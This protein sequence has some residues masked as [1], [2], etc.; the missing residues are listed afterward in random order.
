MDELNFAVK[1]ANRVLDTP[2]IDPDGDIVVLS[3]QF[4]RA[5]EREALKQL[6]IDELRPNAKRADNYAS[7]W[8]PEKNK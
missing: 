2:N 6:K 8:D 5:L 7:L 4:L 1:F 3:R